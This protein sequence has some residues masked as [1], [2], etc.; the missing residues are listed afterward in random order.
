M[1]PRMNSSVVFASAVASKVEA[2]MFMPS[3]GCSRLPTTSPIARAK[4]DMTMKYSSASPPILPTVAAFAIEPTP[5]TIVQKMIGAIIILMSDTNAVPIGLSARPNSGQMRPTIAP[6]TTAMMTE[7]YS[8]VCSSQACL[9][10][11]QL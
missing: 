7:M 2:A 10:R 5:T 6:S 1:I 9:P 3:P 4:V 11:R 8:H